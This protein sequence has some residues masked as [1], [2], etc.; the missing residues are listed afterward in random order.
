[1][2]HK[3]QRISLQ[4]EI[5]KYIQNYISEKG[6]ESGD[7]LPS[8]N[9][10]I[11]MMGVSRTSLR[12]AIKTLE[13]RGV[14]EVYNGKGI[15]VGGGAGYNI[16]NVITFAKEKENL[17]EIVEVRK[18][19]E[20]EILKLVVQR[21]TDEELS[22]LEE[23]MNALMDKYSKG[24]RQTDID[25]KFHYMIY[26]FAHNEVLYELILSIKSNMDKLWEFPLNMEEPFLESIPLH[27]ELFLAIKNKN[28][29]LAQSINEQL[30]DIVFN[31]IKKQI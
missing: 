30:L 28:Y 25:K 2:Q 27:K 13:A 6:L 14:L 16:S 8:Q 1:M 19:L 31:E 15:Y 17:I 26:K 12:E 7:K 10:L 23:C 11:D 20:K 29:K 5:I 4:S 9:S 21:V 3:I 24:E 18:I 22:S